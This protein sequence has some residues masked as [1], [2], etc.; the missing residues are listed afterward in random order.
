MIEQL[1]LEGELLA[2]QEVPVKVATIVRDSSRVVDQLRRIVRKIPQDPKK[3]QVQVYWQPKQKLIGLSFPDGTDEPTK[4]RWENYL[5]TIQGINGVKMD[6]EWVPQDAVRIKSAGVLGA[7]GGVWD[8]ANKAIGGPNPLTNTIAGGLLGA[9]LGY[10]GGTMAEQ[11][12]PEGYFERGKL[13]KLLAMVGAAGPVGYGLW[14]GTAN[15]RAENTGFGEGMLSND[16]VPVK[17]AL[18]RFVD[19]PLDERYEKIAYGFGLQMNQSGTNTESI[20]VDAFN[21]AVW[22][23]VRMGMTAARNPYGTK[24]PWGNNSQQLHTPMAVGAATTGIMSGIDARTGG[25]GWVSPGDIVRGLAGAGVGLATAHVAGK[26]LGT[27]AG[28]RPEAQQQLQQA[29]AFG[30]LLMAVVPSL[31]GR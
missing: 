9:G 29:G 16:N 8:G 30:G 15:A 27:L 1:L 10:A 7:I 5:R 4:N 21:N 20:P 31:F 6:N 3:D 18:S 26:A 14:K 19:V 25:D 22:N 2:W 12:L 13:R 23:D 11:L 17:A 28:L 24:S